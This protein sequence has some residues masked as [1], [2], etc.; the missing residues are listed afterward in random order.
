MAG[1]N[2]R[3][4]DEQWHHVAIVFRSFDDF[5]LFVDGMSGS[6]GPSFNKLMDMNRKRF[7][8][9]YAA[10]IISRRISAL[11]VTGFSFIY[12]ITTAHMECRAQ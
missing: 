9:S 7:Q 4:D 6:E 10:F 8:V 3:F 12:N 11:F 1:P 2:G 5:R